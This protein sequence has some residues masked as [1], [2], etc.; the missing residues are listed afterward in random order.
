[1][2][3]VEGKATA[4]TV[5]TPVKPLGRLLLPLTFWAGRHLTFTLK[6]LQQLS[7]IHYA[8]WALIRGFPDGDGGESM[9]HPYLF[10]ESNFNGTWDQ[11]IDA[12]SAVLYDGLDKIWRWSEKYPGSR[13]VTGFKQYI[14]L[15]QFD[16][17]YYFNAYP[18]A[19]TNDVKASF[20]ANDALTE[21]AKTSQSLSPA[22]FEK[23]WLQFQIAVSPHLG[24]T[25]IAPVGT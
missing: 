10:F 24:M 21:F 17:D 25:G 18:H 8:R 13:P 16:T 20:K 23:A 12:F 1:V 7:F 9:A 5:V 15:V 22:E 11:Y 19:T 6:K 2:A 14:D 3:N 4:I